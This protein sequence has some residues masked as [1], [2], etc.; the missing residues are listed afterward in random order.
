MK[1]VGHACGWLT[2]RQ[3]LINNE[4]SV[5][6][7]GIKLPLEKLKIFTAVYDMA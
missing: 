6:L 7:F 5:V 4:I 1:L 2:N 3:I